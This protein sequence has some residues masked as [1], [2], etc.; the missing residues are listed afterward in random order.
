MKEHSRRTVELT[1]TQARLKILNLTRGTELASRAEAA[2]S[3]AARNKGLLGRAALAPG[4]GMWIAPCSS[5][6]TFFMKFPIDLVY[7]DRKKRVKK[8]R[9]HVV[10]WR[11]S[12]CFMAA[13]ILELPSGT[14]RSTQTARGD[15]LDLVPVKTKSGPQ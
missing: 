3:A 11:I 10:P 7:L 6:H 2:T 4:E 12:A 5:V 8:V 9:S 14:I 1:T 15:Q 13:S